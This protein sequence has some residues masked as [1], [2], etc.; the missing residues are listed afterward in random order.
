MLFRSVGNLKAVFKTIFLDQEAT[1]PASNKRVSR[2]SHMLD[3]GHA[4]AQIYPVISDTDGGSLA[5]FSGNFSR[6]HEL[7]FFSREDAAGGGDAPTDTRYGMKSMRSVFGRVPAR[8]TTPTVLKEAGQSAPETFLFDEAGATVAYNAV[9]NGGGGGASL[10]DLASNNSTDAGLLAT[11]GNIPSVI[12]K[13]SIL[14]TRN[15]AP[16]AFKDS[17]NTFITS[18][19]PRTDATNRTL[20]LKNIMAALMLS[21][22][23]MVRT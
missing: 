20:A 4:I 21:P 5:L 6:G 8:Y 12:N 23:G 3:L 9:A 7:I 17:L 13:W 18:N 2:F 11:A 15:T 14:F 19:F 10:A 1:A 22:Y 16:Q